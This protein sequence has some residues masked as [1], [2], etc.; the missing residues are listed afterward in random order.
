MICN[1]D[2]NS[3]AAVVQQPPDIDSSSHLRADY[4]VEFSFRGKP[5]PP[6]PPATSP[7]PHQPLSSS[8]TSTA[9]PT[10]VTAIPRILPSVVYSPTTR[11]K[12]ARRQRGARKS[13][14]KKDFIANLNSYQSAVLAPPSFHSRLPSDLESTLQPNIAIPFLPP[15]NDSFQRPMMP[16]VIGGDHNSLCDTAPIYAS[17]WSIDQDRANFMNTF[18]SAVD[19]SGGQQGLH[20]YTVLPTGAQLIAVNQV[21]TSGGSGEVG[22]G[23]FASPGWPLCDSSTVP[24]PNPPLQPSPNSDLTSVMEVGP[25]QPRCPWTNSAPVKSALSPSP[26]LVYSQR[27]F[28]RNREGEK[29]QS[30]MHTGDYHSYWSEQATLP[31]ILPQDWKPSDLLFCSMPSR[32][33]D[34]NSNSYEQVREPTSFGQNSPALPQGMNDYFSDNWNTVRSMSFPERSSVPSPKNPT[35]AGKN[36]QLSNELGHISDAEHFQSLNRLGEIGRCA[37]NLGSLLMMPQVSETTDEL[38]LAKQS[39][40][41]IPAAFN[42]D[43]RGG[44]WSDGDRR[45]SRLVLPTTGEDDSAITVSSSSM[46]SEMNPLVNEANELSEKDLQAKSNGQV[47]R[48]P[49]AFPGLDALPLYLQD[50]FKEG[51]SN[52][53]EQLR[54]ASYFGQSQP[55]VL[56]QLT[57]APQPLLPNPFVNVGNLLLSE[58]HDHH[59]PP[60]EHDSMSPSVGAKLNDLMP[61]Y[62]TATGAEQQQQQTDGG[63]D[64]LANLPFLPPLPF[65]N[66]QNCPQT[67]RLLP[68]KNGPGRPESDQ[69]FD[70][71]LMST[72]LQFT[73][74]PSCTESPTDNY[75]APSTQDH[76]EF[77][78]SDDLEHFAKM[79]KQRRIKLGYTQADVG[80]ALGTL[81]GNV[82]SQTTICRF[83][84]LQLSF[85]NMCKLKP[86]LQKWLHEADCSTGTTSSLDKIATQG[87][88]RKKRT[89]IEVGVKGVLEGHFI[90]Q[91]KPAAMDITQLAD[92]LGLEKEVVRVWF[93]N[94]RQKQKRLNPMFDSA[95]STVGDHL[96]DSQASDNSLGY[97]PDHNG[98]DGLSGTDVSA[99]ETE[100][101]TSQHQQQQQQQ[102]SLRFCTVSESEGLHNPRTT[103]YYSK[104]SEQEGLENYPKSYSP[105][106]FFPGNEASGAEASPHPH[107]LS[108]YNSMFYTSTPSQ[109][110]P[111]A[112]AMSAAS[113]ASTVATAAS[114]VVAVSGVPS[115]IS[116]SP[117]FVSNGETE[118]VYQQQQQQQQQQNHQIHQSEHLQLR[119]PD[120]IPEGVPLPCLPG[121]MRLRSQSHQQQQQCDFLLMN[122]HHAA[123]YSLPPPSHVTA[124]TYQLPAEVK[125]ECPFEFQI[126]ESGLLKQPMEAVVYS[127]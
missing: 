51:D 55:Q 109:L 95:A 10:T 52:W 59:V 118:G 85:K 21:L 106:Q 46:D 68:F 70:F 108:S 84:A 34:Y 61:A 63:S 93:C 117:Q 8:S 38:S 100:V 54:Q 12:G 92:A 15:L 29:D 65:G 120:E 18:Q 33:N 123:D 67:L 31:Q 42:A 48:S 76:E 5:L 3:A 103:M 79:F 50:K 97:D 126:N 14:S 23:G 35:E 125:P 26:C 90:K 114:A 47:R 4:S 17:P 72:P 41:A 71:G 58:Q 86:L 119:V 87:R 80:L 1:D 64:G 122:Q 99:H 20:S 89:S 56:Q 75:D 27:E 74:L 82:F 124:T 13:E 73:S 2:P 40:H 11:N 7:R 91:P 66:F 53:S 25:N 39:S 113:S 101:A 110:V 49:T 83:E 24:V 77:P 107:L 96:T 37:T 102:Q 9:P 112:L 44:K 105:R 19:A 94:R 32:F 111:E 45:D 16:P 88:K 81:Y 6:S 121:D 78:S 28:D 62:L 60:A 116:S 30:F 98:A 43:V 104:E 115:T 69:D 127:A 22:T 57:Q 36:E